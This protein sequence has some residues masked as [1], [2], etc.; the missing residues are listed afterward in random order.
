M[1]LLQISDM[2]SHLG[3]QYRISILLPISALLPLSFPPLT[4]KLTKSSHYHLFPSSPIQWIKLSLLTFKVI[5]ACLVSLPLLLVILTLCGEIT[6]FPHSSFGGNVNRSIPPPTRQ[7]RFRTKGC[8]GMPIRLNFLWCW[9]LSTMMWRWKMVRADS[10][11]LWYTTEDTVVRCC[12]L[13]PDPCKLSWFFLG[14]PE[15]CI[16]FSYVNSVIQ[17]PSYK[18]LFCCLN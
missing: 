10:F 18:Y 13:G 17:H 4:D 11:W 7:G 16:L 5:F 8:R 14:F 3:P 1:S 6:C 9:I 15:A 12:Y 2:K